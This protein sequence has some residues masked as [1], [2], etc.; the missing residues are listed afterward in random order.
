MVAPDG[1]A[2]GSTGSG[3]AGGSGGSSGAVE[4]A[5]FTADKLWGDAPLSTKL[6]WQVNAPANTKVDCELDADGDGTFETKLPNCAGPGSKAVT[7]STVGQAQP[8][9]RATANGMSVEALETLYVNKIDWAPNVVRVAEL[10]GLVSSVATDTQVTLTFQSAANVPALKLGDVLFDRSAEG[11]VRKVTSVSVAGAKVDVV[12]TLG[13]FQDVATGGFYGVRSADNAVKPQSNGDECDPAKWPGTWTG[14]FVGIPT[15][16]L[17]SDPFALTFEKGRIGGG[18][19]I[20]EAVFDFNPLHL[21]V[22]LDVRTKAA[23]CADVS[24]TIQGAW[25]P[26]PLEIPVPTLGQKVSL[27]LIEAKAGLIPKVGIEVLF[28]VNLSA[29]LVTTVETG[30]HFNF[31]WGKT[32]ELG[33]SVT[34]TLALNNPDI[35]V[36]GEAKLFFDPSVELTWGKPP[37]ECKPGM[38]AGAD[39]RLGILPKLGS[40]RT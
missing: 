8:R 38:K 19:W 33:A 32:L 24:A 30:A 6:T 23:L 7:V 31:E 13:S 37:K 28:S 11:Y 36:E 39:L 22:R 4:I 29:G 14:D 1:G 3:G 21:T 17:A 40:R 15:V 26:D 5:S 27:G 16:E 34:P 12:T 9:L 20:K 18:F 35:T 25:T 2:G 10:A